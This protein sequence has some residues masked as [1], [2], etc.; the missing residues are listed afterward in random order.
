MIKI[1]QT[2]QATPKFSTFE[3]YEDDKTLKSDFTSDPESHLVRRKKILQ[4]HPEIAKLLVPTKSSS[5]IIAVCLVF[6]NQFLTYL[7]K[8]KIFELIGLHYLN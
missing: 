1:K 4:Q 7:V 3:F 2:T 8:F 5:L 6:L